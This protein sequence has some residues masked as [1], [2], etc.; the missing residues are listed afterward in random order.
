MRL[1]LLELYWDLGYFGFSI[2]TW[3]WHEHALLSLNFEAEDKAYFTRL[4]GSVLFFNF[5]IGGT[6]K[7]TLP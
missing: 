1:Q 5:C 2:F 7:D 3:G 6:Q 4:T